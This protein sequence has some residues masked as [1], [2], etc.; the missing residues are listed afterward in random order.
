MNMLTSRVKKIFMEQDKNFLILF[1]ADRYP[2]YVLSGTDT[3][4]SDEIHADVFFNQ[5]ITMGNCL[6][7]GIRVFWT[8]DILT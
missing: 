3:D 1:G 4:H 5:S 8:V 2:P 6:L 7:I